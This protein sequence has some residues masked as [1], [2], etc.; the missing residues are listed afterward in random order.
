MHSQ[1]NFC[2]LAGQAE[3][4]LKRFHKEGESPSHN[5]VNSDE[6]LWTPYDHHSEFNSVKILLQKSM[7]TF[8][9]SLLCVF[10]QK[11]PRLVW[12]M[13][14]RLAM[15]I[16][17]VKALWIK[18]VS[19]ISLHLPSL[20]SSPA[21][22]RYARGYHIFH[23]NM[24]V[25]LHRWFKADY[26]FSRCFRLCLSKW[27]LTSV[28]AVCGLKETRRKT[29]L[30]P[31]GPQLH[32]SIPSPTRSSHLYSASWQTPDLVPLLPAG[33]LLHQCKG[34]A[35]SRSGSE[36][37][38]LVKRPEWHS[39]LQHFIRTSLTCWSLFNENSHQHKMWLLQS[40]IWSSMN[41]KRHL[42]LLQDCR[43]LKNFSSL[44]AILSALQS[45]AVY[46]LR[47][48]WAAVNR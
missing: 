35:S 39:D 40:L 6:P 43:Q 24:S 42:F 30:P 8:S 16:Q 26:W 34:P 10:V 9:W 46:R 15:R 4:L 12:N 47:K 20:N 27:C 41:P 19:W 37:H 25:V 48:T 36:W 28:W 18:L 14:R 1:P 3:A 33:V 23:I 11:L 21:L 38:R 44:R 22:I 17:D 45:N 31:F 29:C 7:L 2:S 13:R 32:S 5:I